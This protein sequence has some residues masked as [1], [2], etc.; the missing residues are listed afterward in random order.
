MQKQFS[1]DVKFDHN[2]LSISFIAGLKILDILRNSDWSHKV[3][4]QSFSKKFLEEI[5]NDLIDV[6]FED[7]GLRNL[8]AQIIARS[9]QIV[10]SHHKPIMADLVENLT[11]I[12]SDSDNKY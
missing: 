10:F 6:S 11:D 3:F 1:I 7:Y 8:Q 2:Q 9:L 5:I 12:I 4:Q